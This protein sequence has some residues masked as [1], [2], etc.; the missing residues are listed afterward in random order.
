MS[1]CEFECVQT[2]ACGVPQNLPHGAIY[3]PFVEIGFR[4]EGTMITVG[5]HSSPPD[6]HACIKSFEYGF[7][8]GSGV[9]VEIYD[10]E[11]SKLSKFVDRL[12]KTVCNASSDYKMSVDFGWITTDCNN[13]V[14]VDRASTYGNRLNFLPLKIE[15]AFENGKIKYTIEGTDLQDRISENRL[16]N[17]EG[18]EDSKVDLKNAIRTMFSNSCPHIDDV[19]FEDIDGNPWDFKNSDGGKSGPKSVWTTDQ[20]NGLATT[21]KWIAPLST[22]NDKGV[23]F[24]WKADEQDP[25]IVLLEDPNPAPSGEN[26]S[27][28]SRNIG[29]YI[30]NGGNCSPVLSFTP[31]I[32]WTLVANG[33]SGG[34]QAGGASGGNMKQVG[35]P[36]SKIERV[37]SQTCFPVNQNDNLWRPNE[38]NVEK[39]QEANANHEA[40]VRFREVPQSINAELKLMGEPQFAYPLGHHGLV[41]R[42]VSIIVINP[43]YLKDCEWIAEPPCNEILSNKKWMVIGANHQIREGS[44]TTTLK[45]FLEVPN[46]DSE[47]GTTLG[48][49]CGTTSFDNDRV[50]NDGSD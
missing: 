38:S 15:V 19:R 27:C 34:Q 45:L 18:R 2:Y 25:C 21:R 28:C 7:S 5:N 30:V 39:S 41:G 37:G 10:E 35:R 13:Q 50:P 32:N 23:V 26:A 22:K 42:T 49:G 16:E 8:E 12:S 11:G 24:Q 14:V 40:A 48:A 6:N 31:T 3:G 29:T 36:G 46:S 9:K 47:P 17:G 33:G 1:S 4:G 43:F 44:Y 20:Q